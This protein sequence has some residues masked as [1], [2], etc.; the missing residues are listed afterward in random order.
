MH[1]GTAQG[2]KLVIANDPDADRLAAA[3]RDPS[4]PG[5]CFLSHHP[6]F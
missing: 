4:I 5:G 3:E 1:A 6:L 2:S